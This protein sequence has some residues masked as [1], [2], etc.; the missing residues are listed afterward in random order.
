MFAFVEI[1]L[2]GYVFAPSGTQ[3][4]VTRFNAWLNANWFRL[5]IWA[6]VAAGLY[7]IL[8]GIASAVFG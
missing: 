6:L 4:A 2:V 7:L 1:P 8:R 3:S 5:A